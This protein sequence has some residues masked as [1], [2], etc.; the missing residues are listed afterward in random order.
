MCQEKQ[1]L[2]DLTGPMLLEL[3]ENLALYVR[4]AQIQVRKNWEC[5]GAYRDVPL[6]MK[7]HKILKNIF[8]IVI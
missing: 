4:H 8:S 7:Y 6:G 1:C 3:T 2:I 5:V